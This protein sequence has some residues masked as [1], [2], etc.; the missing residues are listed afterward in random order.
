[1][2]SDF[3]SVHIKHLLRESRNGLKMPEV[4]RHNASM[5]TICFKLPVENGNTKGSK[6]EPPFG[7]GPL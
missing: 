6:L 1:M 2:I 4:H 5:I 3:C 7:N